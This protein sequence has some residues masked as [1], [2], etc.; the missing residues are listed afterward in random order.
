[1][2]STVQPKTDNCG[3]SIFFDGHTVVCPYLS[4]C[5]VLHLSLSDYKRL[6]VGTYHGTSEKSQP[7]S[8]IKQQQVVRL[9]NLLYINISSNEYGA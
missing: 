4:G 6:N 5:R 1:M 7:K 3:E 9:N 8:G 2:G